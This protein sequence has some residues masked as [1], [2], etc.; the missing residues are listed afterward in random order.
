MRKWYRHSQNPRVVITG[1]SAGIG[2]ALAE[3][4]AKAGASVALLARRRDR[5]E[6]LAEKIR[7]SHNQ[8]LA[9]ECD[10]RNPAALD[11]AMAQV[12]REWGGL[13]ILIANAGFSVK[14]TLEALSIDDYRRQFETNVF[15]VLNSV[16][17]AIP[18]LKKS[19]G[20][21][22]LVGSVKGTFA[23]PGQSA[24]SMS[25]F[26]IK[27]LALSLEG[28]LRADGI[29]VTHLAPGYIETDLRHVDNQGIS[30]EA[31]IDQD[32]VPKLFRM[33][34]RACAR[35][36]IRAIDRRAFD[37]V[38][39]WHGKFLVA[40]FRHHPWVFRFLSRVFGVRSVRNATVTQ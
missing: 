22:A 10:V 28:E 26:A 15:G 40:F 17:A 12:A 24:Y 18:L 20:S 36:M 19:K 13:D 39:T 7:G 30:H 35:A 2:Q 29:S 31:V 6:G 34:P 8:V 16:K 33:S 21:V 25:K 3:E 27:A 9:I 32:R 37:C 5:I 14:G 4:Y 11:G 1:A 23:V 38:I